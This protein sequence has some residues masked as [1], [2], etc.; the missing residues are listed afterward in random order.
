MTGPH[1]VF[2]NPVLTR[3]WKLS[4]AGEQVT[5][6]KFVAV[7]QAYMSDEAASRTELTVK[8]RM[9][10]KD[11]SLLTLKNLLCAL[12]TDVENVA[13]PVLSQICGA[14]MGDSLTEILHATLL[15]F[16]HAYPLLLPSS[17]SS[18]SSSGLYTEPL[19]GREA[20]I[21][22]LV[23]LIESAGATQR[24]NVLFVGAAGCGKT[25]LAIEVAKRLVARGYLLNPTA[26]GT[27][28]DRKQRHVVDVD[29]DAPSTTTTTTTTTTA[30]AAAVPSA[31]ELRSDS[32]GV[33][34]VDLRG[35]TTTTEAVYAVLAAVPKA[36]MFV[37]QRV[38]G[39]KQQHIYEEL[40]AQKQKRQ[41]QEQQQR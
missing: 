37:Q 3:F 19:V 4:F 18:P 34:F 8:M 25:R 10:M 12:P 6:H 31:A 21:S 15:A 7:A 24:K 14:C 13:A 38:L 26:K 28:R 35:C 29:D 20:E 39:L 32:E 22:R 11:E 16:P 36:M 33:Y 40:L 17:S 27:D 30:A 41:R 1:I 23:A 5:F 9:V 2:A